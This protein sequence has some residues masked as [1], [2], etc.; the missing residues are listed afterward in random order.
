MADRVKESHAAGK[1]KGDLESADQDVHLPEGF[2]RV[3]NSRF[4]LVHNRTRDLR[5]VELHP[6]D[7]Q[8]RKDGD[9]KDDD[10]HAPE[11][12]GNASPEEDRGRKLFDVL[13]DGSTGRG[14]T[15]KGLEVGIREVRDGTGEKKGD[16]AG[17]TRGQ[18]SEGDDDHTVAVAEIGCL[19]PAGSDVH[20]QS[21][22]AGEG[23][24]VPQGPGAAVLVEQG[25]KDRNSH[26][27][28]QEEDK[29]PDETKDASEMHQK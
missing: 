18:P 8:E 17:G 4:E 5:L 23:H 10:A 20:E 12:L 7:A 1:E 24:G 6:S 15:G 26:G 21:G 16:S 3:G 22:A 27:E 28:S 14:E 25:N 11:P 9:G 13:Q 2:G 29:K 19:F